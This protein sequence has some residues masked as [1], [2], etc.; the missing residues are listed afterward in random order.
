MNALKGCIWQPFLHSERVV[1]VFAHGFFPKRT[2]AET[3]RSKEAFDRQGRGGREQAE[4]L[5]WDTP[6]FM[7]DLMGKGR[8]A[9]LGLEFH[10][11][12]AHEFSGNDIRCGRNAG[13]SLRCAREVVVATRVFGCDILRAHVVGHGGVCRRGRARRGRGAHSC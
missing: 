11:Y 12:W 8:I 4:Q 3:F 7:D 6:A 1:G 10:Q 2:R 13:A 5:C 9:R